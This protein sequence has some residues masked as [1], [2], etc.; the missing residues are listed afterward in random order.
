MD[1]LLCPLLSET[2]NFFGRD[3]S[4]GEKRIHIR[5]EFFAPGVLHVLNGGDGTKRPENEERTGIFFRVAVEAGFLITG[6][7]CIAQAGFLQVKQHTIKRGEVAQLLS[8][9]EEFEVVGA[10][11]LKSRLRSRHRAIRISSYSLK[12]WE[13]LISC[14]P[15]QR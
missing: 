4:K 2:L 8:K 15:F 14:S 11:M 12:K 5:G 6:G 13:F 9:F 3:R 7:C 10:V 1:V